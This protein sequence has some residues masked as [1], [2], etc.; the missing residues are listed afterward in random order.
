[1]AD[2]LERLGRAAGVSRAY[3]F[4]KRTA[5]DGSPLV[6]QRYEWAAPGIAPQIGN[7]ALQGFALRGSGLDRWEGALAAGDVIRC[8]IRELDEAERRPLEVQGILSIVLVPISLDGTGGG[9]SGSTS[10][11]ANGHGRRRRSTR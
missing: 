4:E 11:R 5:P 1:M 10:A 6:H 8:H 9:S 3:V 7:P 2:V